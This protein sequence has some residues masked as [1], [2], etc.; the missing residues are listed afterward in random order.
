[1]KTVKSNLPSSSSLLVSH[2]SSPS[3]SLSLRQ[4]GGL[5]PV[6][7]PTWTVSTTRSA[8]TSGSSTG[9]SGTTSEAP[10]TP[11]APPPWWYDPTTSNNTPTPLWWCDPMAVNATPKSR[12]DDV[13]HPL[14]SVMV[15]P[16]AP[17]PRWYS[18]AASNKSL[19]LGTTS[20][21]AVLF[22]FMSP[23][24]DFVF[25]SFVEVLKLLQGKCFYS[26]KAAF[27]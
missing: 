9:S 14:S 20:E 26:W 12:P 18:P 7:S 19:R 5:T 21:D 13:K 2:D 1:M 27:I 4:V 23:L 10:A 22:Y 11:C 25:I 8:T 16:S 6:V 24:W 17:L 3:L 15:W